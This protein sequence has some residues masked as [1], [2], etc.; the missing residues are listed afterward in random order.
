[1]ANP[2]ST[3]EFKLILK[4]EYDSGRHKTSGQA[5]QA[6]WKEYRRQYGRG[7]MPPE[8]GAYRSNARRKKR[9]KSCKNCG[10][11][12]S[13]D[14]CL[15]CLKQNP[16]AVYN[17]VE[18]RPR[19]RVSK[20]KH[21][22]KLRP[23]SP[24]KGFRVNIPRGQLLPMSIIEIRYQRT[25]GEYHRELFKHDFNARPKVYGLPDGSLLLKSNKR[26]WGTV[27]D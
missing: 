2:A 16:I 25:G 23:R 9:R 12:M 11:L 26:L 1:M 24:L 22:A 10:G 19:L 17:P 14:V 8:S 18:M 4:D 7:V 27:D 20:R 5:L 3:P 21:Q 13:G 15:N 6:A